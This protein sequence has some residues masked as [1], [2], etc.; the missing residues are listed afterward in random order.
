MSSI[1]SFS[2][3]C[4]QLKV[5]P[6]VHF[7]AISIAPVVHSF[8]LILCNNLND[9][10][11]AVN[12]TSASLIRGIKNP[13]PTR[14]ILYLIFILVVCLFWC[15]YDAGSC[16]FFG[17]PVISSISSTP[18]RY[19]RLSHRHPLWKHTKIH[20]TY[21]LAYMLWPKCS[22]N[23]KLISPTCPMPATHFIGLRTSGPVCPVWNVTM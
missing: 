20:F 17:S 10:I 16:P 12:C 5:T 2:K 15:K 19:G 4:D 22:M 3:K 13:L 6:C 18:I 7:F 9:R 8:A 11:L 14:L 1:S 23:N 21:V